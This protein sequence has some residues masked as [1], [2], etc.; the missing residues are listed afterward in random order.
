[1][2]SDKLKAKI[3]GLRSKTRANG[4]TEAEALAAAEAAARLMRE[5]GLDEVDLVMTEASSPDN[6]VKATWRT[7]LS[8]AI[9]FCTNTA[10]ILVVDPQNGGSFVFVGRA[11]G[12]EI[13]LYLREVCFRAVTSELAA[14]KRSEFYGRRRTVRTKRQASADFVEGIVGRLVQRLVELFRPSIDKA[15]R[16]EAKVALARRHEGC[17]SMRMPERKLRFSEAAARG[18][19]AGDAIALNHGVGEATAPRQLV[20][21][22]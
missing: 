18:W 21:G 11:P 6:S 20:G 3:A 5:H 10:A 12:P 17:M 4:C 9:A 16:D 14:F 19:V 2:A 13:G 8:A 15:A 22:R 1:M 7:K